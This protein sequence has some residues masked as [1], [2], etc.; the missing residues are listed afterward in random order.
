MS[1]DRL[2]ELMVK[3][4]DGLAT[5]AEVAELQAAAAA[6]PELAAELAAHR[7]LKQVTDGWVDRLV[8]DAD[9][10]GWT[11]SPVTR[12]ERGLGLLLIVGGY[13]LLAG[14]GLWE[15]WLDPEAPLWVKAGTSM[16][17]AG[18]AVMLASVVRWKWATRD[19]PYD[20]VVR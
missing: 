4:V 11:T 13:V 18:F 9:E 14:F 17:A 5:P 8:R 20:E 2:A 16:I 12:S 15:L 19:D 6:D 7:S 1:E 3:H 10:D